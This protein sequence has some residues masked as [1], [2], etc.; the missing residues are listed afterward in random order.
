MLQIPGGDSSETAQANL[1][2]Y[3]IGKRR[4]LQQLMDFVGIDLVKKTGNRA[5]SFPFLAKATYIEIYYSSL[6]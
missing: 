6:C 1:G 4:T 2:V 3:G 5:V